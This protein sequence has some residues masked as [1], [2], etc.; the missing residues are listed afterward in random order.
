MAA[1][2]FD[3][4]VNSL[5]AYVKDSALKNIL[6]KYAEENTDD[7]MGM[8][9]QMALGFVNSIPPPVIEYSYGTFP[10]PSLLVHQ[11]AIECLISNGIV[12]ARNELT[13][14]NGGITVKI[15]DS[16]RYVKF[17]QILVRMTDLEIANFTKLKISIN[18]NS[19][20]GGVYSPYARLHGAGTSLQANSL[21]SG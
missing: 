15:H 4:Y 8:Y 13:Y 14:N 18:I 1:L 16:E 10:I 9:V 11:A 7:E 5:R 2:T 12:S 19:G 6:L 20:W 3:N 21:L 17:I